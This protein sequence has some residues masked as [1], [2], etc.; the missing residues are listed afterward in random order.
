MKISFEM[1]RSQSAAAMGAG[2]MGA[3]LRPPQ[4]AITPAHMEAFR[5]VQEFQSNLK[6][7][8]DAASQDNYSADFKPTY[9]SSNS[10]I[11]TAKY[12]VRARNRTLA[13]DTPH[14]KAI[15]RT[16][17]NNVVGDDPFKLEMSLGDYDDEGQFTE[18]KEINRAVETAWRKFCK[19]KNFTVR[20]T[21]S[22][23]ECWRMVEASL[24]REGSV[25][26]RHHSDYPF[27][28]FGYAV[29]FLEED[30][31]QETFMGKSPSNGKF[32][33]GNPIRFSIEYHPKYNFPLAYWILT[34]HPGDVLN[35]GSYVGEKNANLWREQVPAADILHFNNLRDRAE[36]DIGMTELDS[37]TMPLWRIHQYEKALTLASIAS[38]AKPWWLEQV[39]PTGMLPAS[40]PAR[41]G[42][43]DGG[44]LNGA[45]G[46]GGDPG[47]LQQGI[48]SPTTAIK[49]A[50]RETLPPGYQLKQADPRFP[51]EA[52]H[53]FRQDNSR[54][55]AIGAGVSYQHATG[56]FQ[57]LGFIAGLMCQIP[58]Q[59]NC[60]VRQK[61]I[62]DGG[63][64]EVFRRWLKSAIMT[65]YFEK[66]GVLV[67]I[68]RFEEICEA[69][70]FKGKRWPFV[71]P[72]VQ[73]QALILLNEAGHYTR[74]Q[75]QDELPHGVS[76]EKL[77][78]M[79]K[80]EKAELEQNG[81][82]LDE[83]DVTRPTISKGEP[84][85]TVPNP[86]ESGDGGAAKVPEKTKTA[87]PLRG[88]H[89]AT[90]GSRISAEMLALGVRMSDSQS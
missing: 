25:I 72:L 19:K 76:F 53:E 14:G 55:I 79:L 82:N 16:F 34:R 67:P 2:V 28:E 38:N 83:I 45:G 49:P 75:V 11:I 88:D 61:N 63:V 27:N 68:S 42:P 84:G 7:S 52:A 6:R 85:A 29:D 46:P 69:A 59:D 73:A 90:R 17:Q 15:V 64:D 18:E 13:K 62:S 4:V 33:A 80:N 1:A 41:I 56:D 35:P 47:Q 24:V 37:T 9:G 60:K 40:D 51:I 23:M 36:Q 86:T 32:G 78:Q 89:S 57:N 66:Q 87:N 43:V 20:K 30:R 48:A 65:G 50:S 71:N 31:L 5:F 8:Y 77:V 39:E 70:H 54:D 12:R 22:A 3:A 21:M 74:Q 81:L 26:G 44:T 58:F 10:E